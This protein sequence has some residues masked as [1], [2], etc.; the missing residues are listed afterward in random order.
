MAATAPIQR[1]AWELPYTAGTAL[2][3]QK[4]KK[5]KKRKT[6]YIYTMEYYSAIKRMNNVIYSNMDA[7]RVSHTRSSKKE[8]DTTRYHLYVESK[9]WQK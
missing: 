8:K 2:E 5:K 6:W 4:D 7:T 9:T 3:R 1:L